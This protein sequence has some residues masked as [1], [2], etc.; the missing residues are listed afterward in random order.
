MFVGE[1]TKSKFIKLRTSEV[2]RAY[3][4]LHLKEK[5]LAPDFLSPA[6]TYCQ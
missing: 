3:E 5:Q 4:G 6:T 1:K 2:P